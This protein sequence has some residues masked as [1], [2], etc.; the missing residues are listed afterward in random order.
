MAAIHV[1]YI[2]K[3]LKNATALSK[4]DVHICILHAACRKIREQLPSTF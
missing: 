1:Y 2:K 4:N 3:M